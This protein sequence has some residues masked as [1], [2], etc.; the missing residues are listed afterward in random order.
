MT[1]F[2]II[3]YYEDIKSKSTRY[4]KILFDLSFDENYYDPKKTVS[5]FNNNYIEYEYKGDKDKT[6]SIKEYFQII[7]CNK[8]S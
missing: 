5:A 3:W 7:R 4:V 1:L 2:M 8:W 6:L